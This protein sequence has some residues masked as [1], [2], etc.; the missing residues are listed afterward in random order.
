MSGFTCTICGNNFE[1]DV[2]LLKKDMRFKHKYCG[3][4]CAKAAV[5]A[6]VKKKPKKSNLPHSSKEEIAFGEM[7]RSFFP[8][9]ES[10]YQL[11]NYDHHYDFYSP[12]LQLLIEYDGVYYHSKPPQMAKDKKHLQAAKNHRVKLAVITDKDW[13]IFIGSGLPSKTKLLKLLNYNIKN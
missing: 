5:I 4:A 10:Q 3:E 12:E 13:E 1:R 2:T 8:L 11:K 7:V 6:K 9:L